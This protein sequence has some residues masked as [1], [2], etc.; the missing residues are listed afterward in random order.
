MEIVKHILR[1]AIF[2]L[3]IDA[4]LVHLATQLG[5]KCIVLFGPTPVDLLG[6]PQ[7]INITAGDCQGCAGLYDDLYKCARNMDKPECMYSIT[8]ELV[9]EHVEKYL[10]HL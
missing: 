7:N 2:H 1:H 10:E 5:T 9:L 8:P 6:Y 4:G 3:D